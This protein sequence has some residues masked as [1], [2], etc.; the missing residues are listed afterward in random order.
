MIPKVPL[1]VCFFHLLSYMVF[2]VFYKCFG[3]SVAHPMGHLSEALVR[4][5]R[6]H[7]VQGIAYGFIE[8]CGFGMGFAGCFV[9]INV[10]RCP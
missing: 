7:H 9:M 2:M 8:A 10:G 4:E 6:L 1:H 5:A 3:D